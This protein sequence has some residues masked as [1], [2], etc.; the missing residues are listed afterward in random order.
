MALEMYVFYRG[1]VPSKTALMRA[2]KELGF[3]LTIVEARSP[4][5][6]HTGFMP[7]RWRGEDTGFEFDVS[8]DAEEVKETREDCGIDPSLDQIAFFRFGSDLIELLAAQCAAAA[9]AKLTGGVVFEPIGGEIWSLDRSVAEASKTVT[10]L[11]EQKQ[12]RPRGTRPADIKHYLKPLLKMRDD[13]VL[14]GRFLFIRPVRHLL[15]GVR[16]VGNR[17]DQFEF[18]QTVQPLHGEGYLSDSIGFEDV[19]QPDF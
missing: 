4:L 6:D 5:E 8:S 13:L 7:I 18:Y 10:R 1:K 16:L 19:W 2:M 12:S 11:T 9:L 15:R 3:P 14:R 17:S